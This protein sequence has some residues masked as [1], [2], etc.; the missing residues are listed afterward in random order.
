MPRSRVLDWSGAPFAKVVSWA[1]TQTPRTLRR[2]P[3]SMRATRSRGDP[4]DWRTAG[5]QRD[6]PNKEPQ[7]RGRRPGRDLHAD[8]AEAIVGDARRC[9]R[10][11]LTHSV[12][13]R[14]LSPPRSLRSRVDGLPGQGVVI[15]TDGQFPPRQAGAVKAN[16]D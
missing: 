2:S 5:D 12:G 9:A 6:S 7:G 11:G 10:L 16:V 14:R 4:L 8:G 13:L 15:T 3:C 1:A